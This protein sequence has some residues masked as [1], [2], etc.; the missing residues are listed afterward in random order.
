[1]EVTM[2]QAAW[3]VSEETDSARA[4]AIGRYWA[5][6]GAHGVTA[7]AQ[8]LHGGFGF[9]RDYPLHRYFLAVKQHEFLL[10]GANA[11]LE[12]LG[13]MLAERP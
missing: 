5:A 11:Q 7:A 9:D 10:G 4:R 6:E 2:W 8:H 1:M 3:R 13:A 12:R